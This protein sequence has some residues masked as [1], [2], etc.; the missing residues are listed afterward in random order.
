MFKYRPMLIALRGLILAGCLAVLAGCGGGADN[1]KKSPASVPAPPS[2]LSAT[3]GNAAA[4]LTWTA[5]T[6]ATGYHVKRA[7]TSGGPYTQLASLTSIG[8]TDSTVTNGIVY[9]Y[10]VSALNAAGESANSAE[11]SAAPEAP[12]VSPAA[13]TNLTATAGNTQASLTWSASSGATSYHVKRATANGGPY[14]QI[15]APTS[16]SYTDT[17]LT[18][19]TTYYYVVSALDSAGESV[20]SA[21]VSATPVASA[22]IPATPT[23]LAATPGNALVVLSWSASAGA[24]SYHV[25]RTTTNGGPYTQIA[26]P[27]STSYTDISLSNGTTYYYVV[28]AINSLGESPNSAQVTAIPIAAVSVSGLHVSGNQILNGQNQAVPL[29]GVDKSGTEY[30]CLGGPDIFD[31]PSDAASVTTLKTWAINIV[32][33]PLNEDCWLGINGA[34]VGGTAYQTAII[35][36]VNLLTAGNIATILDLQW[37]APGTTLS[38]QLTPMPDSDHAA[39]FWASVA[40][41]FNSNRSVIFD[42]FNEPY[43]DSNQDSAAAWACLK[44]GGTCPGVSYPAAS[45]QSLVNAI[46][47]TGNS[48]IIMVPGV[49][50]TNTLTQWLA[51]KPTDPSNNLVASWHSYADQICNSQ[52]CWDSVVKPVLQS[53]PLI[54]GEIGEGDCQDIYVNPLM[55]YLDANGGNYL[56]WAWDTYD[57]SSFPALISAYDGTPT[58]FGVGVRNH[59]LALAGQTPPP[60]PVVPFFSKTYPFGIAVGSANQYTASDGTIYYPDVANAAMAESMQFFT[61]FTTNDTITGTSDPTLYKSGKTG[62]FGIWT[63]NVPNGNYQVTLGMAPNSTYNAGEYGQDQ[64]IQGQKVGTCVWSMYSGTNLSPQGT[65]CPQSP[66]L[67]APVVDVAQTVTYTISVFNQMLTIEPSASFGGGHTTILNTIK[68]AQVP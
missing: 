37:A 21:Q 36:Y 16:T 10:V 50:Y 7:T 29:R 26:A 64:T 60:P 62:A 1:Q 43:P 63:I 67:P 18:N 23:G 45:T 42:L 2:D 12:S 46:R 22:T 39:T 40:N 15:A 54:A 47:V 48:N 13:P 49:Q 32:R 20:N 65:S 61:P 25:K 44:N 55:A 58:G 30:E 24:T 28:S 17:S 59:L 31:G 5:S 52:T 8:Y 56:A 27:T 19:G 3:A 35:N 68:I 41:A 33:L 57:C 51:N 14:T 38:N 34:A 66:T 53:V 11:V 6:G 9:Y 4:T